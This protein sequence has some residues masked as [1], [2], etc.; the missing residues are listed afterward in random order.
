MVGTYDLQ[1]LISSWG[2][3]LP[4]MHNQWDVPRLAAGHQPHPQEKSSS[5]W[6]RIA[7]HVVYA[8]APQFDRTS[9]TE[10]DSCNPCCFASCVLC[11][12]LYVCMCLCIYACVCLYLCVYMAFV[13][14]LC[15]CVGTYVCASISLSLKF[16]A[17]RIH[18]LTYISISSCILL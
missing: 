2:S 5:I 12:C 1:L 6:L 18:F 3:Y 10:N 7:I 14:V 8:Q 15:A 4:T 9:V 11:V 17:F 13:Y 16:I